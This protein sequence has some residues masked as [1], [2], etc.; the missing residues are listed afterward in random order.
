VE[1]ADAEPDPVLELLHDHDDLNQLVRDVGDLVRGG[2][3]DDTPA[4][5][6]Q[7]K[8][9][10][11]HLFLHF[12]REE[13]GVFPYVSAGFPELA[14]DVAA[15]VNAHDTACGAVARMVHAAQTGDR[16][17]LPGLFERFESSYT[18]HARAE[19]AL[20]QQIA[21]RLAPGHRAE[22]IDLLRGL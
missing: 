14:D 13:E 22:L 8:E 10:R 3:L 1:A 6:A 2:N 7:L 16:A 19:R 9:L 15:M 12:A 18:L 20:L 5:A 17:P 4:L 21:E 11:E